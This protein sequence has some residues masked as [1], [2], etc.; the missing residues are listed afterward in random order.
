MKL[1]TSTEL[2]LPK[3]QGN[4]LSG[5]ST[6]EIHPVYCNSQITLERDLSRFHCLCT[7]R[8]AW[9]HHKRSA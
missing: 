1:S 7:L 9:T 4:V 2:V 5:L 8:R 3:N 6:A